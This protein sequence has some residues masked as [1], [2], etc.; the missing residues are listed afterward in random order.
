MRVKIE[1]I[2][3]PG[4]SLARDEGKVIFTDEGLPGEVVELQVEKN[5]ENFI[6]AKTI[7][8]IETAQSRVIPRCDHYK[9]CSSYQYIDH[10]EQ[11]AIKRGQ[12]KELFSRNL[13]IDL[14]DFEFRYPSRVW[15]YRNRIRVHVVREND[16]AAFAYHLPE[17][18]DKFIKIGRCYLASRQV[19]ILLGELLG[20]IDKTRISTLV[21][22]EI[23]ENYK[24]EMLLALYA[25]DNSQLA[26]IS[27]SMTTLQKNF[28][29]TG[30]V[31]LLPENGILTEKTIFGKN[32]LEECAADRKYTIGAQSFFQVNREMLDAAIKDIESIHAQGTFTRMLDLY[33]GVG[34]F[35]IALAQAS[36]RV[37]LVESMQENIE[38]LKINLA[39][40]SIGNADYA[41]ADSQT[42]LE[43]DE[44]GAQD[45]IIV[46]PPRKGLGAGMCEALLRTESKSLCCISCNPSTLV[47][48]LKILLTRYRIKK[49]IAYDF[50][51]HTP[52]IE[53]LVLLEK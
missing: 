7:Q 44:T 34:T 10:N 41:H 27:E 43:R 20:L 38:Y 22:L 46:D 37:V 52:H 16:R 49:V 6:D 40:N 51:P 2:V 8:V 4:R 36:E 17:K 1:A 30:S 31:V 48:D 21:E 53:T 45:L 32:N 24:G 28:V 5:K 50:F 15:E 19:N 47:R 13:K 33:S 35:G 14:E 25:R 11:I 39:L 42:W 23:K 26:L 3:F 9:T 18:F 12:L 29:L